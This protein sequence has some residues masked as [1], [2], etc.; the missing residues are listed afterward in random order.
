MGIMSDLGFRKVN[1]V[2]N[3]RGPHIPAWFRRQLKW[4]DP[5]MVVQFTPP[6]SED[7]PAGVNP[8]LYPMGVWDVCYRMPRTGLLYPTVAFSLVTADGLYQ[9]PSPW[10]I[11]LLRFARGARR[12][13]TD[14][15]ILEAVD[16]HLNELR[17]SAAVRDKQKVREHFQEVLRRNGHRQW[18][19]R[20]SMRGLDHGGVP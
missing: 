5:R 17:K 15:K 16:G 11:R 12:R 4:I 14:R 6:Y 8:M 1:P 7:E 3:R 13:R 18:S 9:P 20:V 10:M 2:W 19:N